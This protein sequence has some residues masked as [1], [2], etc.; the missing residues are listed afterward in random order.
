[1]CVC[2]YVLFT[3]VATFYPPANTATAVIFSNLETILWDCGCERDVLGF[4]VPFLPR[5]SRD[6][7]NL[8]T[9]PS[10]DDISHLCLSNV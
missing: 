4:Y 9:L 8:E 2:V 6:L 1:M 7:I 5:T 10:K 3:V